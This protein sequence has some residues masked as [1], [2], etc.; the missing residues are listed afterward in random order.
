MDPVKLTVELHIDE[1]VSN[2]ID[3]LADI[4]TKAIDQ[5]VGESDYVVVDVGL[6]FEIDDA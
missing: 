5:A 6:S 1:P 3:E 2:D 4:V